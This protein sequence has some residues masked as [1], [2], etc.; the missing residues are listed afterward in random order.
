MKSC[1]SPMLISVQFSGISFS[2]NSR[3]IPASGLSSVCC[4]WIFFASCSIDS[5]RYNFSPIA[6]QYFASAHIW[7]IVSSVISKGLN[8]RLEASTS[9][10]HQRRPPVW[11]RIK[12]R[13][14]VVAKKIHCLGYRSV[15]LP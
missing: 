14:F 11:S 8:L 6:Y 12:S 3:I 7:S 13:L 5:S 9:I 15:F 10:A 1:L 4:S 2:I